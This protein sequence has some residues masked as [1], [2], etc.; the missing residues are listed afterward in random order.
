MRASYKTGVR[1]IGGRWKGRRIPVSSLPGLRPTSD[2]TRETVFNWL[3]PRIAGAKCLDLFAGSGVLTFEALSRGAAE[4]VA[5]DSHRHSIDALRRTAQLLDSQALTVVHGKAERLLA[6]S[7]HRQFDI[8]FVDPPFGL[9]LYEVV[10]RLLEENGWLSPAALIYVETA[11]GYQLVYPD[12]WSLQKLSHAGNV[13]Y[14]L[15]QAGD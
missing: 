9:S 4:V 11:K 2:R 5:V 10:C 7:A 14:R 13:D 15:L 8:V 12:G 1:I 6:K 3:Q